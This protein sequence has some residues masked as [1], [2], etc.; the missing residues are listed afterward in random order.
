MSNAVVLEKA[1]AAS[2]GAADAG[3][4]AR[5]RFAWPALAPLLLADA[6]FLALHLL[7][8][9]GVVFA[10]PAF[11]VTV[12]GGYAEKFQ[13][14]KE[15]GIAIVLGL[16]A[17]RY[18]SGTFAMW[19]TVFAYITLDDSL[20]FHEHGGAWL[21]DALQLVPNWGLRP[22]DMG[23]LMLAASAGA[24][25]LFMF[26]ALVR[27]G[28]PSLRPV[29]RDVLLLLALLAVCGVG[30]DMLHVVAEERGIRGLGI[31]EDW[32]EMLAMSLIAASLAHHVRAFVAREP[33]PAA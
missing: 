23:E 15:A 20:S 30:I 13:Y 1:L 25:V 32:G 31:V 21:A 4:A 5:P 19:A 27:R 8:K 18:R 3:R 24:V 28:R 12:E 16:L 26:V 29:S 14:L 7:H 11:N 9:G 2:A 17:W 22:I 6:V 10:D 33:A